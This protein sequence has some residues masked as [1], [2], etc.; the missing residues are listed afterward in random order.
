[1]GWDAM[2]DARFDRQRRN[3]MVTSSL[4]IAAWLVKADF[5]RF[6]LFGLS[7]NAPHRIGILWA[8]LVLYFLWRLF[9]MT[10]KEQ[11]VEK[12]ALFEE[13]FKSMLAFIA[14]HQVIGERKYKG[15]IS[16]RLPKED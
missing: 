11:Q 5:S 3:V 8:I 4:L 9:Q 6:N 16:L 1:M 10:G 7:A 12:Q 14:R 2:D 15:R 13:Q